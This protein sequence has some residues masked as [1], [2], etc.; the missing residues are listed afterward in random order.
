[1]KFASFYI[2]CFFLAFALLSCNKRE[3]LPPEDLGLDYFPLAENSVTIYDVDSTVYNDFNNSSTNFKFQLKD[4]TVATAVDNENVV[5]YRIERYKKTATQNWVFQKVLSKRVINN[6]A[7]ELVDNKRYVRLVFPVKTD[8]NWNGNLYN[9][10]DAQ[11]YL[12]T[13]AN[14]PMAIGNLQFDNTATVNQINDVNL[15]R[16]DIINETYA[17]GIGLVL[18]EVRAIDKRIET[19]QIL[20]GSIYTLSLNQYK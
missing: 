6:R 7:E 14:E 12:I 3:V 19:G 9:N 15:I 1:M 16:E 2:F 18:K 13:S 4:T 11:T 20:R 5:N 17:K 8:R 10:D